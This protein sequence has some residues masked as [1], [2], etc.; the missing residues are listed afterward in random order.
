MFAFT[1]VFVVMRFCPVKVLFAGFLVLGAGAECAGGS[2]F[3]GQSGVDFGRSFRRVVPD[4][5]EVETLLRLWQACFGKH[6]L[7]ITRWSARHF[8]WRRFRSTLLGFF[9]FRHPAGVD[10]LL[11]D[12]LGH[13]GGLAG[14]VDAGFVDNRRA[15]PRG[16]NQWRSI[17]VDGPLTRR[18]VFSD[19]IINSSGTRGGV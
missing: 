13:V 2:V 9:R 18:E 1:A 14:A 8:P 10:P 7:P 5:H 19:N 6:A 11:R 16:P 4:T 3:A 12:R 17:L 15:G